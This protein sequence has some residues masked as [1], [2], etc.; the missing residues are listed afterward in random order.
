MYK[1]IKLLLTYSQ[2]QNQKSDN[3]LKFYLVDSL[4]KKILKERLRYDL[5]KA[6]FFMYLA[7]LQQLVFFLFLTL[8]SHYELMLSKT[9]TL[10]GVEKE[11]LILLI[12][13]KNMT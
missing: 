2:K 7:K 10:S 1:E 6:S 12:Q 4:R 5:S 3:L 13:I 9:M 11:L 8:Y